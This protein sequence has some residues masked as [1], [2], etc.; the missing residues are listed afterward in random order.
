MQASKGDWSVTAG[1]ER[2]MVTR[3]PASPLLTRFMQGYDRAFTLPD[4]REERAG[5]EACLALNGTAA[6]T[7]EGRQSYEILAILVDA[8]DRLLGGLNF[9]A[10]AM[11]VIAGHPPVSVAL[12][13]LFVEPEARGRGLSRRLV[14]LTREVATCCFGL[15]G[16][17]PGDVAVFIEQN[18]PF[19][20]SDEAYRADSAHSG[21]DQFDRLD[22]WTRL[23]A[24][25]V[26]V[27]Y[28]QPPLSAGQDADDSLLYAAL[29]F[30]GE[31]MAA[32][33]LRAHLS[34]FFSISVLKG[35]DAATDAVAGPQLAALE[36]AER[37]GQVVALVDMQAGIESGRRN[38]WSASSFGAVAR[39]ARGQDGGKAQDGTD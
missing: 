10:S 29:D 36:R 26:D 2:L 13:Y 19:R 18:D 15:T 32:A 11:P 23:G 16:S 3:D 20:M 21:T 30:P 8:D 14:A 7:C 39:A 24:R 5:F 33:F 6:A 22:I 27:D 1:G 4:E 25:L 38:R 31:T 35:R 37:A 9:L 12:N 17:T 28:V 34:S